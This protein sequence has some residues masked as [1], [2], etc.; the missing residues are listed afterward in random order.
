MSVAPLCKP[1]LVNKGNKSQ[2]LHCSF[3][4]P[5]KDSRLHPFVGNKLKGR[6][7]KRVFQENKA[8]QIFG[9]RI[10]SYSLLA[11]FVLLR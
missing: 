1:L 10:I 9:K 5:V 11:P 7:S 6:I 8:R 2:N 4:I 3:L